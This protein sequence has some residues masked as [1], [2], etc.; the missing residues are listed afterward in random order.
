[1]T[2]DKIKLEETPAII[3]NTMGPQCKYCTHYHDEHNGPGDHCMHIIATG[4]LEESKEYRSAGF[5]VP[6]IN[7]RCPCKGFEN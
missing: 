3:S 2:T 7:Q 4:E 1:M 5:N 6:N